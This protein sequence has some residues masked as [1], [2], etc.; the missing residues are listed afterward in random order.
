MT[1]GAV[2]AIRSGLIGLAVAAAGQAAAASDIPQALKFVV[3]AMYALPPEGKAL[4]FPMEVDVTHENGRTEHEAVGIARDIHAVYARFERPMSLRDN[5]VIFRGNLIFSHV[6]GQSEK[7]KVGAG[8]HFESLHVV[9]Y[10]Q[11]LLEDPYDDHEFVD[12]EKSATTFEGRPATHYK[13]HELSQS[14]KFE[15]IE[16]IVDDASGLARQAVL[17]SVEDGLVW[18][19]DY[20]YGNRLTLPNG[21]VQPFPSRLAIEE[22]KGVRAT[23]TYGPPVMIDESMVP[24]VMR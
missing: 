5:E 4:A 22:S 17:T 2:I 11:E 7:H 24:K 3:A 8:Q 13:F 18:R 6:H 12:S 19:I 15:Y 16:V 9:R 23:L 21:E 14:D 10:I 20:A 1:R